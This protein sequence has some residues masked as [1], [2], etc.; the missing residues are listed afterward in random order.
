MA[1][2]GDVAPCDEYPDRGRRG[3]VPG[4]AVVTDRRQRK[5]DQRSTDAERARN[6]RFRRPS[7][8]ARLHSR[9]RQ[10]DDA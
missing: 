2:N 6:Q 10:A 9:L 5:A 3:K 4:V 8:E 7:D 1:N